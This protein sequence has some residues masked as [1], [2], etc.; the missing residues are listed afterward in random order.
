MQAGL[1]QDA[2]CMFCLNDDETSDHLR[3]ECVNMVNMHFKIFS[4]SYIELVYRH[5]SSFLQK[6]S[7]A[8]LFIVP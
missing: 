5:W 2:E 4:G 3:I 8:A 6:E 7:I 1:N